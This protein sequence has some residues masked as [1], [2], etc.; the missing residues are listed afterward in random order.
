MVPGLVALCLIA[1]TGGLSAA[2]ITAQLA[3]SLVSGSRLELI[4]FNSTVRSECSLVSIQS[5]RPIVASGRYAI[6][7][8][9]RNSSGARCHGWAWATIKVLA[10]VMIATQRIEPGEPISQ[11]SVRTAEREKKPG[12]KP[13]SKIPSEA[14]AATLLLPGTVLE[15]HHLRI[16]PAIGESVEVEV[17]TNQISIVQIGRVVP[18]VAGRLC[19]QLKSGKRLKGQYKNGRLVV[20][21]P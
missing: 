21:V 7:V 10:K 8:M 14:K 4:D 11:N 15:K 17:R 19:A 1:T 16:G 5:S 9:G 2:K 13:I 18:C 20:E 6:K 12:Q 3:Q